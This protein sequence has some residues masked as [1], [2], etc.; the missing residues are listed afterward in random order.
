M[1]RHIHWPDSLAPCIKR[2]IRWVVICHMTLFLIT[3]IAIHATQY[4]SPPHTNTLKSYG[5]LM[6]QPITT[7]EPCSAPTGLSTSTA[8][9]QQAVFYTQINPTTGPVMSVSVHGHD[10]IIT[11]LTLGCDGL[12]IAEVVEIWHR[13]D[14]L[15]IQENSYVAEWDEGVEVQAHLTGAFNMHAPVE[16]LSYT[17]TCGASESDRTA[18]WWI[19]VCAAP[20]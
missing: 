6:G 9:H 1:T 12:E 7:I 4:F 15:K 13:P 5:K 19:G 17:D 16:S 20:R 3:F 18:S 14:H 2:W 8:Y 11:R 10:G